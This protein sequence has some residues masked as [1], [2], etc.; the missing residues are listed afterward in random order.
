VQPVSG[1]PLQLGA[2]TSK[3]QAVSPQQRRRPARLPSQQ[4]EDH[5]LVADIPVAELLGHHE[6]S[7]KFDD[8]SRRHHKSAK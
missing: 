2:G 7:I 3:I 8:R 1:K 6:A 4:A 5:V